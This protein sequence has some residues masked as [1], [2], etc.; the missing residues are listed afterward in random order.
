MANTRGL[1]VHIGV[2]NVDTDHYQGWDG[3]LYACEDDAQLM[4]E[5]ARESGF[6]TELFLTRDATRENVIRAIERASRELDK[7]DLFLL[8]YSGHGGQIPRPPDGR[9]ADLYDVEATDSLD[10]TWCLYDAQLLDDELNHLYRQFRTGVRILL[11][12]DSCHSGFS[13]FDDRALLGADAADEAPSEHGGAVEPPQR[14]A[15]ADGNE[16]RGQEVEDARTLEP[17]QSSATA[18]PKAMPKEKINHTYESNRLF[19][20]EIRSGIPQPADGSSFHETSPASI[21]AISACREHEL[22]MEGTFNGYFTTALKMTWDKDAFSDYY[23]FYEQLARRLSKITSEK[24]T[25]E[26]Y[27]CATDRKWITTKKTAKTVSWATE[28]PFQI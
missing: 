5:L 22:A 17:G 2:I 13:D 19:Y 4:Q 14:R 1:S 23:E 18:R 27:S 3:R 6:E 12:Q 11:I 24:Q 28:P 15:G 10:E 25:A 16:E 21:L 26:M 20:D 9:P 7:G 8:T